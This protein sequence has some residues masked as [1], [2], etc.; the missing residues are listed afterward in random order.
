MDR[1][2]IGAVYCQV[3]QGCAEQDF[4]DEEIRL[5]SVG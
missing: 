1:L 4:R 5:L 3:W 2:D